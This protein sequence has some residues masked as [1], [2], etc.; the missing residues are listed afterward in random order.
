MDYSVLIMTATKMAH[1]DLLKL[2]LSGLTG[3]L[4]RTFE[5]DQKA[6]LSQAAS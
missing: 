2:R 5:I 4:M 6:T 1:L 3:Y